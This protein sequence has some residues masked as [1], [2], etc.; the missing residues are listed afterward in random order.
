MAGHSHWAQ[1]KRAKGAADA[2][3]GNLFGRIAREIT[4]SV[5]L[6]GRDPGF[7]PRL[8]QAISTAKSESMPA[9]TIERAIK[10]GTGELGGAAYEELVYEGYG[11]G[12]IAL[13]VQTTTD[14]KNRT[15]AEIRSVFSKNHGNLGAPGSVGW[16]FDHRG[17]ITL[18]PS[19]QSEDQLM[20]IALDA[21]AEDFRA[22]DESFEVVTAP[23][24]LYAVEET[25]KK[26]GVTSKSSKF[27]FL[28]K[29]TVSITDEPVARQILQLMEA[30]DDQ[31]DVQNVFSNFD[32]A[33]D[34]LA[35]IN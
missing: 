11:A 3:R 24:K 19:N 35:K 25:M 2:K 10:K 22:A 1:I 9:D 12:G 7:N 8:R 18:A 20:E 15:A 26:K 32:I 13:I 16:M 31:D 27:V 14:N 6:G 34:I 5:K 17:L 28:P 23:E 30:L 29:N 33:E 21:G 4:M